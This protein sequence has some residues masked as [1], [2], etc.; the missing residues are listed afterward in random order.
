MEVEG[1]EVDGRAEVEA[2]GAPDGRVEGVGVGMEVEGLRVEG[3]RDGIEVEGLRVDGRAEEKA[4]GAP[5]GRVK[6]DRVG[7]NFGAAIVPV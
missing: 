2:E 1:F 4:E 6:G 3:A 5:D 7:P